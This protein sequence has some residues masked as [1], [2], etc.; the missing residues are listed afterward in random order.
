MFNGIKQFGSQGAAV[1]KLA[2]LQKKIQNHKTEVE[3]NDVKAVVTG[4]GKLKELTIDG[5]NM[6][7]AVKVINEAIT[8][9]QKYSAE[10]MKDSMGDL[11][12][13][14]ANMPKGTGF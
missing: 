14:L 7:K 3:E 5:E 9:A 4:D 8:K 12:K 11:S 1:A 13:V 10:E 2:M 6:N